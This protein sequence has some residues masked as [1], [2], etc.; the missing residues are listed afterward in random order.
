MSKKNNDKE[1]ETT[2]KNIKLIED[3]IKSIK[4]TKPLFFQTNKLKKHKERINT[5]EEI[6]KNLYKN[7]EYRIDN[8]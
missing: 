5:L 2:I 4:R 8:K 1:I 3:Q 6:Q 7:L